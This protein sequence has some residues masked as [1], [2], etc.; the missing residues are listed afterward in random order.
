MGYS[1]LRDVP[2][3]VFNAGKIDCDT[4]QYVVGGYLNVCNMHDL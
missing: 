1:G 3:N 4:T 2:G